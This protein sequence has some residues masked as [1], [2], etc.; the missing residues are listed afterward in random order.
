MS[1]NSSSVAT[2]PMG[3]E[4]AAPSASV[5]AAI[6]K[7]SCEGNEVL[8]LL[9]PEQ[10]LAGLRCDRNTPPLQ[11]FFIAPQIASG[12][13]EKGDVAGPAGAALRRSCDRDDGFAT[14]QARAHVGDSLGFAIALAFGRSRPCRR[15]RPRQCR[16]LRRTAHLSADRDG[17]RPER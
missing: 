1:S 6:G 5:V 3:R 9:A 12:W 8:N 11:R 2:R 7:D 10:P 4:A 14:D 13:R 15:H 16:G 17:T